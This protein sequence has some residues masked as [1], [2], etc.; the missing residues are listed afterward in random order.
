[1]A[2]A[3]AGRASPQRRPPW[4]WRA[5]D[6]HYLPTRPLAFHGPYKVEEWMHRPPRKPRVCITH[7]ISHRNNWFGHSNWVDTAFEAVDGLDAEVI[8]LFNAKQ[9]GTRTVPGN[10]R[11]VEFAPLN[12]LLPTC[13]AVVHHGGYGPMATSLEYGV[14]QLIV[15]NID[16][17]EKWWGPIALA[18]GVEEQGAGTYVADADQLTPELLREH[19]VRVLNDPSVAANALRLSRESRDIPSPN[20]TVRVLEAFVAEHAGARAGAAG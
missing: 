20:E 12:I 2:P 18:K 3:P 13:S 9:V 6:V 5:G 10:V 15:P 14:P 1:M 16:S 7:G 8:A 11:A 4:T 17:T 19:I